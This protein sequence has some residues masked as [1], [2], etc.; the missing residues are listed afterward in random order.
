[1]ARVKRGVT[2]HARHKKVLKQSKGFV[3]RSSTNYRI[4]LERLEKALRYAYRDRRN[5][6]RE[7][8][9]LWIQRINAAVREQGMTYSQFIAALKAAN[10]ELDRK[11]LAAMAFDDPAGFTAIVEAAKAV[12]A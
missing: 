2:T 12:R 3:G 4:A 5:K 6:K 10:I 11:V 7:F 8:R 9:A 1:M